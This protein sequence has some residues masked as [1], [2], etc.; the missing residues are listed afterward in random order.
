[1]PERQTENTSWFFSPPPPEP[2]IWQTILWWESRRPLY[3]VL[4]LTAAAVSL[5]LL[6]ILVPLY[7]KLKPGEDIFEPIMLIIGPI[8]MNICYTAGSFA[9]LLGVPG[10]FAPKL[11]RLGLWFSIGIVALPTVLHA[12]FA[13][14][15]LITSP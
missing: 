4:V 10:R 1:M 8:L 2:S 7:I 9:R 15:N 3:N 5:F 14:A 11:L 13:M 12:I 6:H